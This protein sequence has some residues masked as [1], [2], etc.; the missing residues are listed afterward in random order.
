MNCGVC[1]SND[2]DERD[3]FDEIDEW[4]DGGCVGS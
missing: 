1:L 3:A 2:D 4:E